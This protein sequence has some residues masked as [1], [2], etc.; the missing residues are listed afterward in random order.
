MWASLRHALR[1][2]AANRRVLD[3]AQTDLL[4]ELPN[5]RAF[6]KR[7]TMAFT[8]SWR[9]T[10][11]FAVLYLD[12]DDFAI[13][14][15]DV[16][17]PDAAGT[18]AARIRKALAQP[19]IIENNRVGITSSIGIALFS[20]EASSPETMMMQADL[21]LYG[22]KDEGR[23][24]YR[25]HSPDLDQQVRERVRIADEL[26]LALE[27]GDLELYYQRQVE[28]A[29]GSIT[30]VEAL[31]RWNHKTRG[32]LTPAHFIPIAERTGA[33]LPLGRWVFEEACR[34][35]SLWEYGA[36]RRK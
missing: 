32:V 13:L 20:P 17:D 5:R 25:F 7:L 11:R 21:A 24:C 1:L 30:G 34:Q 16:S 36:S 6:M 3:L 33:V 10:P 29:S 4:T 14:M 27:Q 18:A 26:T 8:G 15:F 22:A 28:L 9:G 35:L 12:I 31:I 23:N 2:E 19:F